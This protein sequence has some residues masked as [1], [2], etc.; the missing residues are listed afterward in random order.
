MS[1]FPLKPNGYF[2]LKVENEF[3]TT[4]DGLR[5]LADDLQRSE[6]LVECSECQVILKTESS[7]S[8]NYDCAMKGRR[9]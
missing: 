6:A 9:I 1:L 2:I 8:L 7:T 5:I 3:A 4:S